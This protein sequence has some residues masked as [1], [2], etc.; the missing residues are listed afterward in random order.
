MRLKTVIVDDE[1]Q[2]LNLLITYCKQAEQLHLVASF[3]DPMEA[4]R[5]INK[6]SVDL[7]ISD[8]DMPTMSGIELRKSLPQSIM[9]IFITAHSEFAIDGF[10]LEAI[11]YLLK[12]V[13]FPRFLKAINK[14]SQSV[15]TIAKPTINSPQSNSHN[16]IFV[17]VNGSRLRISVTE[18]HYIESKGDYVMIYLETKHY[19][20]LQTLT[21]LEK[22]IKNPLFVRIHRSYI[23]NLA[24][25]DTIEK[26]HL[27]IGN[28]D[29][30][31]GKTY[32]KALLS[33]LD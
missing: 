18:I 3:T 5:F 14:I 20:V 33:R 25:V 27:F 12:P 9:T 10:D 29:F 15:N 4:M 1:Q 23:V 21:S 6:N 31:I 13:I 17:K 28:K 16:F 7:L 2:A 22:T 11:D 24:H 19:M 8:I 30:T 26:D 32:R